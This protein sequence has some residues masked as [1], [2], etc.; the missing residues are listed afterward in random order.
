MSL[1][2]P[3][4][5]A[6]DW[7]EPGP[8]EPITTDEVERL[9]ELVA[10]VRRHLDGFIE[11]GAALVEIRDSRLYR[12]TYPTFEAFCAAEFGIGRAH[13]YRMIDAAEV[14]SPMGDTGA[15]VANERQARALAAA[16]P[17]ERA[18]V[19]A[20]VATKGKPTAAA[21]TDEVAKRRDPTPGNLLPCGQCGGKVN[22]LSITRDGLCD[23]C[24]PVTAPSPPP[25]V[26]PV[27]AEAEPD[28]AKQND[29]WADEYGYPP[30][31][32]LP[33]EDP[34]AKAI[35]ATEPPPRPP[36]PPTLRDLPEVKD[37][38]RLS[39]PLTLLTKAIK[40]M[41]P[42]ADLLTLDA[43][44]LASYDDAAVRVARWAETWTEARQAARGLRLVEGNR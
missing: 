17:E 11:A 18:D 44:T 9:G 16:P 26:P 22:P 7:T 13:A 2:A 29:P 19:M 14:V 43:G 32:P 5:G 12:D 15:L 31:A 41:P 28:A 34:I 8:L 27:P 33:D 40:D 36:K 37:A 1:D 24:D 6:A 23:D 20:A 39:R 25:P 21:I 42:A 30:A 35:A 10:T 38:D 3:L 4:N